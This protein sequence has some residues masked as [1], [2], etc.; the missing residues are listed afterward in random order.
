MPTKGKTRLHFTDAEQ[1]GG[2]LK[3]H[4]RAKEREADRTAARSR[5]APPPGGTLSGRL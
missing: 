1:D 5:T 3:E 4:N 2:R